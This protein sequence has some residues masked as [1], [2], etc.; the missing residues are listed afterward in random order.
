MWLE[1]VF[2]IIKEMNLQGTV[3]LTEKMIETKYIVLGNVFIK[4]KDSLAC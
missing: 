2:W 1:V 3:L 4:S